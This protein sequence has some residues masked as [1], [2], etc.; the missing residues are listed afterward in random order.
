MS[1]SIS[2]SPS[3]S[4]KK[5]RTRGRHRIYTASTALA[6]VAVAASTGSVVHGFSSSSRRRSPRLIHSSKD[7]S[8]SSRGNRITA[9]S[10]PFT[11]QLS[12]A[13]SSSDDAQAEIAKLKEMAA[14]ARA[15]AAALATVRVGILLKRFVFLYTLSACL[16]FSCTDTQ[17]IRSYGKHL[18]SFTL[19]RCHPSHRIRFH[20]FYCITGR[21]IIGTRL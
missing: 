10:T 6:A 2:P 19:F 12:M 5:S 15:E 9:A 11:T 4:P 8:R 16:H 20:V 17:P 1:S 14:K 3:S 13:A 7:S 18:R 21:K